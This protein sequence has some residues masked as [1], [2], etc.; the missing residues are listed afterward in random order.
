MAQAIPYVVAGLQA[1]GGGS[2][3][4]GALL[5]VSTAAAV[6]GTAA[7]L[8]SQKKAQAATEKAEA[9]SKAASAIENQR[10]IRQNLLRTRVAQAQTTAAGFA[11]GAGFGSSGIQGASSSIATQ[12]AANRGNLNT[13]MAGNT[14]IQRNLS[15]SR[16]FQGDAATF[17]A[18]ANLPGQFGFGVGDLM[19]QRTDNLNA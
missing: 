14:A 4:T 8:R 13:Q 10:S 17:G 16:G 18:I 6:G 7:S 15:Q 1:V 3:A 11:Q 9:A 12:G 5:T 2:A 19:K